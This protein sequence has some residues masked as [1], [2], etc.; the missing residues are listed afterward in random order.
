MILLTMLLI[1]TFVAFMFFILGGKKITIG[2]FVGQNLLQVVV[3]S[4]FIFGHGCISTHDTEVWNGKIAS[5]RSEKVS[6]SHS[7]PCR[8]RPVSCGKNCTTIHCDTCYEHFYDMSW[9]AFTTNDETITIDRV[10]RQGL[11]EPPRWTAVQIGEPT[12]V[13]HSYVNYIKAAPDSLFRQ[14]GLVE[15]YA[16]QLSEYPQNV[17]DYYRLDRLVLANGATVANPKEWNDKLS[18]I[19]GTLGARKQVNIAVVITK[20]QPEEYFYALQQSWMGGKKNDVVLVM[21]VD[22]AGKIQWAEVMAWTVDKMVEVTVKD[23]VLK[24]GTVVAAQPIIEALAF[25]VGE[26]YNRKSMK[27]FEYLKNSATPTFW[28]WVTS[29]I[30]GLIVSIGLGML[31]MKNDYDQEDENQSF[32]QA[33]HGRRSR[34]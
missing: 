12:A 18:E 15:K 22:E 28:T 30:V 16:N 26:Y 23:S 25:N 6:C 4:A 34:W 1:P 31:F 24:V 20:N 11:R 10:D 17:Y 33:V 21:S 8:C 19:N 3:M 29:M 5:K 9:R 7:Y 13:T 14:Q 27:D 2:E 32:D